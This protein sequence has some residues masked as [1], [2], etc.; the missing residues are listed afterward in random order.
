MHRGSAAT[1]RPGTSITGPSSAPIAPAPA[2]SRAPIHLVLLGLTSETTDTTKLSA[3]EGDVVASA[4]RTNVGSNTRSAFYASTSPVTVDE[5]A[6]ATVTHSGLPVQEG[7]ALRV[8]NEHGRTRAITVTKN[9]WAD[10]SWYYNVHVWDTASSPR[11]EQ[12]AAFDMSAAAHARGGRV[13]RRPTPVRP[14]DR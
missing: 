7:I 9:V 14:S 10:V 11:F 4:P 6:C 13:Q 2:R 5:G 1:D 8:T 12:I 3:I